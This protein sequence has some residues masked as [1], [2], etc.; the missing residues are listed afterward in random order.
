[1]RHAALHRDVTWRAVL[2]YGANGALL[3][4]TL[5]AAYGNAFQLQA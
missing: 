3:A 5:V 1:M 4:A 2:W